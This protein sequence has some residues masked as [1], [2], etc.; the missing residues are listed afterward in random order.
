MS[1][2]LDALRKAQDETA[3]G[4]REVRVDEI[5]APGEA[6]DPPRARPRRALVWLAGVAGVLAL[7]FVGGL[8]LGNRV[9]D[10]FLGRS[11]PEAE[12]AV[13]AQDSPQ[14]PRLRTKAPRLHAR[15]VR[16]RPSAVV[17]GP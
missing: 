4:V 12:P 2:I 5:P 6:V 7:A 11:E 9:S 8:A 14:R 13:A 17:T 10:L 1:T 16:R 15:S 3:N